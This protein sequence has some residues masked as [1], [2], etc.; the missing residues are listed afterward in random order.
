MPSFA[1][2]T[3]PA[4]C[5]AFAPDGSEVRILLATPQASTAHFQLPG[6]SVSRAVMHTT[7]VEIW[8]FLTG[9][10]ELWRKDADGEEASV[11]VGTGVCITIPARTR[12]QFR[13]FGVEPLTAFG[14]TMPP[15]PGTG[16]GEVQFVDG[17]WTPLLGSS[18]AR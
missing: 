12:F 18:R 6:G 3:L 8:Y 2:T 14:V 13:A 11:P 10:G 1:T 17:P 15:W 4:A 7:I 16:D 5:D 9:T